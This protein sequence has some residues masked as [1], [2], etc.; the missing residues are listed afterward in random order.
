[1]KLD[2][3]LPNQEHCILSDPL[4]QQLLQLVMDSLPESI[5]WKDFNS[6]YLGCNQKFAKVAGVGTPETIIGK[7]DYDLPWKKEEAEFFRLCDRRVMDSNTPELGIIEPQLQADGKERWL[8]TNKM[9]LHDAQGHVIGILG[10]FQDIT[11]RKQAE[12]D[13]QRLNEELERRVEERTVT[14]QQS[15]EQL[16]RSQMQMIQAEK[17]SSLG[18]L[19][20]GVAHEINNSINFIHGNLGHV[21]DYAHQM[22]DCLQSCQISGPQSSELEAKIKQVDLEFMQADLPKILGSMKVGSDRVREI[23]LSLRNFSRLDE[24]EF[25]AVDLHEGLENTLLILSHRFEKT[26]SRPAIQIIKNYSDLPLVECYA[27]Q[28]NQ[29][30]MNT[31]INAIDAIEE[32]CQEGFSNRNDNYPGA[33]QIQTEII[34]TDRVKITI[35]DN[36]IGVPDNV[37]SRLFDPFF[38]TKPVGKGTG[39]GLS[40]SYQIITEQHNGHLS[41][42]ATLGEGSQFYIEIPVRQLSKMQVV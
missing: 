6:V 37:R 2:A 13:L 24:A 27:G 19:V 8:E 17:M 1:M 23:V 42:D 22:M 39:L 31:L 28:M 29:V 30:F 40:I 34:D 11:A 36:G 12:L 16:Q 21:Q 25:K 18:Q 5:F 7:N 14:L 41:C 20:A 10:T 9:P 3:A 33:I 15:L 32:S 38:T 26:C 35:S 4:Q